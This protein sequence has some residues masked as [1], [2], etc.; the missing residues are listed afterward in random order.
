MYILS[1]SKGLITSN[2]AILKDFVSG[3]VLC[4]I[5]F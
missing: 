2:D 4:K 1:T 3:E 5:K